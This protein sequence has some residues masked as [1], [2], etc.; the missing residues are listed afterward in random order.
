MDALNKKGFKGKLVPALSDL[1][2]WTKDGVHLMGAMC[3]SC[4]S[5]FF[6]KYHEQHRPDCSRQGI[7]S[8]L[9][10]QAGKLASYTIQHYMPPRPFRTDREITPYV[11]GLVEFV[12]GIQVAGIVVDCALGDLKIGIPMETTTFTLYRDE[13]GRDVVTW[14]FKPRKR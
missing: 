10:S 1:L 13:E 14:A 11:I 12:E 7:R 9:L 5:Y 2:T 3:S 4:G 8:I 6:P